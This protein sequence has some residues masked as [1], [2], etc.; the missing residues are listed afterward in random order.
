MAGQ[1]QELSAQRRTILGKKVSRLRREGRVPGIVYGPM[2]SETVPVSVDSRE[3][4]KFFQTNGH[5]TLFVLRW[6]DGDESV[7]IREVQ[8]DPVRR[9]PIHI[10]FFAPNLRKPVRAQV[11]I[12]LRN[13]VQTSAGVLTEARTEVEVEALPSLIP[14]QIGVDVSR[15]EQPGD[16]VRV[17][18][19]TLPDG[20]TAVTDGDELV[21][22]MEAVYQ[23]PEEVAEE[24]APEAEAVTEVETSAVEE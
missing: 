20:V 1:Q 13:P 24:A 23:A 15:L 22:L 5:A 19:L 12:V 21:A 17:R 3:F 2:T 4:A 6:E 18:D 11:P 9:D 8:R 10:D 16:A 7:F 14:H